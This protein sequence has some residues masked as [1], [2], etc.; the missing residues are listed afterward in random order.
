MGT[1]NPH[2]PAYSYPPNTAPAA[3]RFEYGTCPPPPRGRTWWPRRRRRGLGEAR[4]WAGVQVR[5]RG[6][7]R[8]FGDRDL[9]REG[10]Y[11]VQLTQRLRRRRGVVISDLL[12]PDHRHPAADERLQLA[13][14][15][16]GWDEIPGPGD[17]IDVGVAAAR[18]PSALHLQPVLLP[19]DPHAF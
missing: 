5:E 16:R 3:Y 4:R 18:P 12:P 11:A 7:R 9:F 15:N 17:A 2:A 13:W 8:Q 6:G 10:R 14:R 19:V 1:P